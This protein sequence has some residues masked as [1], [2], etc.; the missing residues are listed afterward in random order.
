MV[1]A[2]YLGGRSHPGPPPPMCLAISDI[3]DRGTL[4]NLYTNYLHGM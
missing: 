3:Y 1:S 4:F 2:G